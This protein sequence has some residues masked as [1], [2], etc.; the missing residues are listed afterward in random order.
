MPIVWAETR[1]IISPLTK[2]AAST[3]I[4]VIVSGA[5]DIRRL[6]ALRPQQASDTNA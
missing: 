6:S 1:N 4:S 2:Q 3:P 5:V